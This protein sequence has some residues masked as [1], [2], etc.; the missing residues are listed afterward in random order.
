MAHGAVIDLAWGTAA[1]D[2]LVA[3]LEPATLVF[4]NASSGSVLR[5]YSL[6]YGAVLTGLAVSPWDAASFAL[7]SM[8]GALVLAYIADAEGAVLG[9]Q[10]E[11]PVAGMHANCR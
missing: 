9:R 4:V 6:A 11:L 10:V 1:P 7:T 5:S 8:A 2:T 3:L